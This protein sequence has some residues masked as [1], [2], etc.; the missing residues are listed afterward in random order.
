VEEITIV[1][2]LPSAEDYRRLRQAVG[3]RLHDLDVIE[4]YLP[5]SLFGVCAVH[6]GRTIGMARVI[7]DG[8]LTFY[9]QDVVIEPEYQRKGVGSRLMDRVMDYIRAHANQNSVVGL[10][11]AAGKEAFYEKYGFTTRPTDKLGSGMTIF[12]SKE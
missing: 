5:R 12:W 9:V 1:E 11:S 7:G 8:G 10:M 3:W 2:I 6:N 4:Q